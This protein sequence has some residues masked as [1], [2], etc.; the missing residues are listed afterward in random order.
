MPQSIKVRNCLLSG[1]EVKDACFI[2]MGLLN[3]KKIA[4]NIGK[5]TVGM[6]I[7]RPGMELE[8]LCHVKWHLNKC[9]FRTN[10]IKKNEKEETTYTVEI[11]YEPDICQQL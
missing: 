3:R 9:T 8:R 1:K 10:D 7:G 6:E 11:I 2:S 4:L 5:G